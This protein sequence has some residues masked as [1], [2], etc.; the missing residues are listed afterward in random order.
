MSQE[1][2]AG[3]YITGGD[4]HRV[5]ITF[6]AYGGGGTKVEIDGMEIKELVDVR[7][8]HAA[9]D[10]LT[11][12]IT[13]FP[14]DLE[15]YGIVLPQSLKVEPNPSVLEAWLKLYTVPCACWSSSTR[16]DECAA[17]ARGMIAAYV[18]GFQTKLAKTREEVAD[19]GKGKG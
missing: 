18:A 2:S 15:I 5:R 17:Y 12:N 3:G 1:I 8:N 16:C 11:L 13:T 7:V 4:G 9:L 6:G 14:S 19:G 10:I